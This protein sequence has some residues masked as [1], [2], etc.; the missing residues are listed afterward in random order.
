[1][2]ALEHADIL[3]ANVPTIESFYVSGDTVFLETSDSL[4]FAQLPSATPLSAGYGINIASNV[5]SVDTSLVSTVSNVAN[6]LQTS[7]NYADSL[8][9]TAQTVDSFYL[10]GDTLFLVL[11][12]DVFFVVLDSVSSGLTWLK[13]ELEAG[14]DV[15]IGITNNARLIL[16][17][18]GETG[19]LDEAIKINAPSSSDEHFNYYIVLTSPSDSVYFKGFDNG[20]LIEHFGQAL[21]ISSTQLVEIRT[22]SGDFVKIK[23]G[24]HEIKNQGKGAELLLLDKDFPH[25]ISI[26]SPDTLVS[27]SVIELPQPDSAAIGKALI[28]DAISGGNIKTKWGTVTGGGGGGGGNSST[29]LGVDRTTTS[30]SF[31]D[32]T[33]LSVPISSTGTYWFKFNILFEASAG[34]PRYDIALNG[35][36]KSSGAWA[37]SLPGATIPVVNQSTYNA[38]TATLQALTGFST[39]EG[40]VTFTATGTLI[41]RYKTE[42]GEPLVI[43]AGS[44]VEYIK[45]L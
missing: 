9:A 14:N 10:Y 42:A 17:M 40:I 44:F 16:N 39:V 8:F 25:S 1:M 24:A 19:G 26:K 34:D 18:G 43:K 27:T 22:A 38:T 29:V 21:T 23:A 45:I 30:G 37:V 6:N 2:A 20:F 41:A 15:V 32:V 33:D 3:F 5:V 4:Y 31:S 7:I 12:D 11:S 28:V 13:P 35:P 36:T